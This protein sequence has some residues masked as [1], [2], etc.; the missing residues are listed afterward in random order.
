M[1]HPPV[2]QV[3]RL[4]C[5]G[6]GPSARYDRRPVRHHEGRVEFAAADR[7]FGWVAVTW[8]FS[9]GLVGLRAAPFSSRDGVARGVRQYRLQPA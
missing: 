3:R 2:T 9:A 7:Q 5:T 1:A 8:A 4:A 6:G